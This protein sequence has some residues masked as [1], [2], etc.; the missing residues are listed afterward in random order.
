MTLDADP[1]APEMSTRVTSG[2]IPIG[3]QHVRL[4]PGQ[5]ADQYDAARDFYV[6]QLEED[7]VLHGFRRAAG[8]PAP[9]KSLTGWCADDSRV[10]FGQWISGLARFA[11]AGDRE[12]GEK[13]LRL[14]HGWEA[15]FIVDPQLMMQHY[16]IDKMVGGLVDLAVHVDYEYAVG[17]LDRVIRVA[18]DVLERDGR[19]AVQ[20][21]PELS[22]GRP[23][24]WYTLTENILRAYEITDNPAYLEFAAVWEYNEF[25]DKFLDGAT[26]VAD[27]HGL[28]AYSH[29]NSLNGAALSHLV[30][31][32]RRYLTIAANGF[33]WFDTTQTY[34]TGGFG[35]TERTMRP[36]GSLGRALDFRAD[37]F[38][39]CCGTW[40]AFKLCRYLTEATG[41]ARF[42]HWA[43]RLLVNGIGAALPISARGEHTYYADYRVAGGMKTPYKDTYACCSGS[44]AQVITDFVDLIYLR[45]D[46]TLFVSQYLPSTVTTLVR[47]RAITLEQTGDYAVDGRVEFTV[48]TA[49]PDRFQLEMAFRLPDWAEY[50][51][52]TRGDDSERM[53]AGEDGWVR[54]TL[55]VGDG[56]RFALGFPMSFRRL[57][58]D[59]GHIFRQAFVRGPAVH[60]F[61][62]SHHEPF[63]SLPEGVESAFRVDPERPGSW[64][65]PTFGGREYQLRIKPYF[66][67]RPNELYRMYIDTDQLPNNFW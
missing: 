49:Q 61:E 2:L 10:V 7:D 59:S 5:W 58:V 20:W 27:V 60:V 64:L 63:P 56:D 18:M 23:L 39:V 8:L 35:P 9:G 19:P 54:A 15:V 33:D 14:A 45:Q 51:T 34:A 41:D 1:T 32:E 40:A 42:G 65:V 30:R 47:D 25:W 57:P 26:E 6:R 44:F 13:A 17:L 67:A 50:L 46:D 21:P 53:V 11:G 37:S 22:D 52:L 31:G 28:H 38:E 55:V 29:L 36:D 62:S 66:Q 24:E 48:A 43:E 3:R 4:L 16:P 12:A